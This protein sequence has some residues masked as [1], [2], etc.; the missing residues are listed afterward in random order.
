MDLPDRFDYIETITVV[1]RIPGCR[2][3]YDAVWSDLGS[4]GDVD[5]EQIHPTHDPI[6]RVTAL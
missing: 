1:C 2:W 5:W 4:D 6:E 3:T